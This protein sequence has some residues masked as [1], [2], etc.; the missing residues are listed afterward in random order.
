M[1]HS[2][3]CLEVHQRSPDSRY[4]ACVKKGDRYI[5]HAGAQQTHYALEALMLA[6]RCKCYKLFI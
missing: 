5:G 4:C 2:Q 1:Q 3:T 6:R